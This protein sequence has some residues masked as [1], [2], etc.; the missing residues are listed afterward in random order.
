MAC[1]SVVASPLTIL[2]PSTSRFR[3]LAPYCPICWHLT[4]K[5]PPPQAGTLLLST[6]WHPTATHELAPYCY[7]PPGTQLLL[8]RSVDPSLVTPSRSIA[9]PP[10]LLSNALDQCNDLHNRA[11]GF[12]GPTVSQFSPVDDRP[13][14]RLRPT[15]WVFEQA[16]SFVLGSVRKGLGLSTCTFLCIVSLPVWGILS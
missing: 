8:L 4:A 5:P 12:S 15:F 9:L 2:P 10:W 7:S 3:P 14:T 11:S 13:S 1:L 6:G 16:A